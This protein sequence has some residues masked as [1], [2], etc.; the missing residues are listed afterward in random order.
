MKSKR[1]TIVI[2]IM[3]IVLAIAIWMLNKDFQEIQL[4][5]KLII[6]IGAALFSGAISYIL[7]P[8][9]EEKKRSR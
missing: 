6:A 7:F 2:P 5:I 1:F 8:E 3:I 9:N 4:G